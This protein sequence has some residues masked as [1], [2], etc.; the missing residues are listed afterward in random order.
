MDSSEE[1][2]YGE[3]IVL[4]HLAVVAD[5]VQYLRLRTTSAVHHAVN[6]RAQLVEQ[7]LDH[8]GIGVG[9]GRGR[10]KDVLCQM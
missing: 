1:W 2:R 10:M 7:F 8:G 5:E 4:N 6:L 3:H 9:E